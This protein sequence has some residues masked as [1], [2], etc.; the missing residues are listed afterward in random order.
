M[1]VE[2]PLLASQ[3][4]P[5][6]PKLG[7]VRVDG[8]YRV[9]KLLGTGASGE[10]HFDQV[11]LIFLNS[12]GRVFQGRDIRTGS[13]VALKIGHAGSLSSK[14]RYEYDVYTAISG[15]TGIP[16]VLWYGKEGQ[17]EVIILEFLGTSLGNLIREQQ[18]DSRKLFLYASQMVRAVHQ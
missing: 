9:G 13:D 3:K 14:L 15:S 4:H 1:H 5:D 2:K 10:P 17:H 16:K 18:L 12:L 8:R 11:C 7:F 6:S